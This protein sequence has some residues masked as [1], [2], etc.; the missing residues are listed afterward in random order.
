MSGGRSGG[1]WLIDLV[2]GT[3]PLLRDIILTKIM[4]RVTYLCNNLLCVHVRDVEVKSVLIVLKSHPR[5]NTYILSSTTHSHQ[6]RSSHFSKDS[7][8]SPL[9]TGDL[10]LHTP[11]ETTMSHPA[12]NTRSRS[13][14]PAKA[15]GGSGSPPASVGTKLS[16]LSLFGSSPE[17]D[18]DHQTAQTATSLLRVNLFG[19]LSANPKAHE[20]DE[21]R[22]EFSS[23]LEEYTKA[24]RVASSDY[25][26]SIGRNYFD[27]KEYKLVLIGSASVGK[28]AYVEKLKSN[29]LEMKYEP[30]KKVEV[31]SLVFNTN[32][33]PIKI[34]FW[35]IAGCE[36]F[37]GYY[38]GAHAAIMMYDVSSNPSMKTLSGRYENLVRVRSNI[39]IVLA[40]N[41]AEKK[42]SKRKKQQSEQREFNTFRRRN[43]LQVRTRSISCLSCIR[44]RSNIHSPLARSIMR[45]Q[46]RL[47]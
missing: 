10:S 28:S 42:S 43:A 32:Y 8:P 9:L 20:D 27:M 14:T 46:R 37:D 17:S 23:L 2:C 7:P 41:K 25:T 5:L 22:A 1:V 38:V 39:P 15:R 6:K 13:A 18:D 24:E 34:D 30:T 26:F 35:D 40:G 29:R 36:P 19:L 33:F 16:K 47:D 12:A 4:T 45:Y 21:L 11:D 44:Y 3:V 31:T